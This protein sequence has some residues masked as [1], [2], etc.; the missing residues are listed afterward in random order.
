M[1]NFFR[2]NKQFVLIVSAKLREVRLLIEAEMASN[3]GPSS[4][5]STPKLFRSN[6]KGKFSNFRIHV[7]FSKNKVRSIF[8]AVDREKFENMMQLLNSFISKQ[9]NRQ[10]S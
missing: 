10:V 7:K 6:F 9:L 4:G 2:E 3:S 8:F 5:S 1:S